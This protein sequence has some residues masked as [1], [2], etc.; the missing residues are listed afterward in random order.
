MG[1]GKKNLLLKVIAHTLKEKKKTTHFN[2]GLTPLTCF[3]ESPRGEVA[4]RRERAPRGKGFREDAAESPNWKGVEAGIK[5]K[6]CCLYFSV[7]A[8]KLTTMR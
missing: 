8:G 3:P 2:V 7:S 1:K 5:E 4:M 6:S